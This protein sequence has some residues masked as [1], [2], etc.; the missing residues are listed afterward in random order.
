MTGE[1]T[2]FIAVPLLEV[3]VREFRTF[4]MTNA[5][6]RRVDGCVLQSRNC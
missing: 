2:W 1:G 3:L 4:E 6:G 5:D